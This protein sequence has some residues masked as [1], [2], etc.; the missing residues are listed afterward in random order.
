MFC[1]EEGIFRFE[2]A[3]SLV[4]TFS[5][6]TWTLGVVSERQGASRMALGKRF[7]TGNVLAIGLFFFFF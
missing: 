3:S 7:V 6:S 4:Y 5:L 1:K 2:L